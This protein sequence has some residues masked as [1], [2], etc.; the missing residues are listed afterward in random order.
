MEEDNKKILEFR[1]ILKSIKKGFSILI[2]NE[3][4]AA[5]IKRFICD[6]ME[7]MTTT[8]VGTPI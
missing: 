7:T 6:R 2:N 5:Q 1:A 3:T 8:T 4:L